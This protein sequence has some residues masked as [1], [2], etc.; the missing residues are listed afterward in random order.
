MVSSGDRIANSISDIDKANAVQLESDKNASNIALQGAYRDFDANQKVL[1]LQANH[2]FSINQFNL[3]QVS[4]NIQEIRNSL[5]G[6]GIARAQH[7][8]Q[9]GLNTANLIAGLGSHYSGMPYRKAINEYSQTLN[10]P[11]YQN[12]LRNINYLQTTGLENAKRE[13]ENSAEKFDNVTFENSNIYNALIEQI[14]REQAKLIPFQNQIRSK[15]AQV[16]SLQVA[17]E[18]GKIVFK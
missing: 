6:M 10:N 1:Q 14:K 17:R 3:Q 13:F 4:R 18:G 15:E 8:N 7:A 9:S 12:T 11:N 16:T 5:Y 2:N